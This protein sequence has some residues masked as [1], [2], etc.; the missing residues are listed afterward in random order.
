MNPL[1]D[2]IADSPLPPAVAKTVNQL[3]TCVRQ[4][5]GGTLLAAAG[6]GIA[7]ILI[8]R[9]LAPAPPRNRAVRLLEDIQQRLA[10]L[11]EDS[12]QAVDQGMNS[13]G[14]LHLDRKLNK[15]SRSIKGLFR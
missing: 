9:A 11:A 15:F 4:H 14:D 1:P 10:G 6:F 5:P 2:I 12:V 3:E 7:V 8:A 13:L